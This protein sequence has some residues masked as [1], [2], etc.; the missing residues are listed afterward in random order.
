M[1]IRE[2][3]FP[4]MLAMFFSYSIQYFMG[5][6]VQPQQK[7]TTGSSGQSFVAPELQRAQKPLNLD[8]AFEKDKDKDA[9]KHV[10]TTDL[11]TYTFSSKGAVLESLN[12]IWQDKTKHVELLSENANCF[13]V[14]LEG[15]T[16]L[17]YEFVKQSDVNKGQSIA[18]EYKAV[19]EGG[20]IVKTFTVARNSYQV[21]MKVALDYKAKDVKNPEQIRVFFPMTVGLE[22]GGSMYGADYSLQGITNRAAASGVVQLREIDLSKQLQEFVFEPKLFGFADKFLVNSYVRS[23]ENKPLRAY[24]KEVGSKQYQAILESQVFEQDGKLEWTFYVGPKVER[25]LNEVAP[26]LT[27]SVDYGWFSFL[28]KPM[29]TVLKLMKN[30]FG[31]YGIAI[32]LLTILLNLLLLPFRL[33]G[34]R[35]MRQQAEFQKKLAYI[36]QKYKHDKA[37]LDAAS[38]EL[39]QKHGLGGVAGCLPMLMNIPFF[40][41][42]SR[43][44]SGSFELYGAS[45]LWLKDLSAVDPYYVLGILTGLTMLLT[46]SP[47]GGSQQVAMRYGTA[48]I[49][50]TLTMY[51][52]SG[53][54][55]FIFINMLCSMVQGYAIQFFKR[56]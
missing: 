48:M 32:I 2:W 44:L 1:N 21:D 5:P 39:M 56:R 23:G 29:L 42:L 40:V 36:R 16:P 45:F 35:S 28:A 49:F 25:M 53:L 3:M 37:A 11:A 31:D 24:F 54:A 7:D 43:V 30:H 10:I 47:G 26:V 14:A 34:E 18:V 15:K 9:A 52:S 12:L 6:S 8:I 46:P 20:T 50:G 41:A 4:L 51:L 13:L 33:K 27:Q 19:F 17:H 22:T 55:L 38:A